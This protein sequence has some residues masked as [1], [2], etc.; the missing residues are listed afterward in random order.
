A[1]GGVAID[2]IF[3]GV[4]SARARTSQAWSF[5]WLATALGGLLVGVVALSSEPGADGH[6]SPASHLLVEL[7]H[8]L[9]TIASV[10]GSVAILL[11][12]ARRRQ[13][14]VEPERAL[15][16]TLIFSL[17]VLAVA[18]FHRDLPPGLL[19]RSLGQ[20][21]APPEFAKPPGVDPPTITMPL[22]TGVLGALILLA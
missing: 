3:P 20:P 14:D 2:A 19:L 1:S 13:K 21:A 11:A 4:R 10:A 6:D 9:V 8:A 7:P 17:I 12:L 15:W 18:L 16:A 22:F 5:P